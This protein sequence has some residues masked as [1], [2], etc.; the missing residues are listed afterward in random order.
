MLKTPAI[1]E[2]TTEATGIIINE[3]VL[4]N[5]LTPVLTLLVESM[6]RLFE[7][8]SKFKRYIAPVTIGIIQ[9]VS[10]THRSGIQRNPSLDSWL[11]R[12]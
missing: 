5:I 1:F 9:V 2:L 3:I 11:S 12:I 10:G 4:K 8:S 7:L 6:E